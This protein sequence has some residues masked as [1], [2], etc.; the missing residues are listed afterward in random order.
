MKPR[1]YIDL[2]VKV[3]NDSGVHMSDQKLKTLEMKDLRTYGFIR[4]TGQLDSFLNDKNFMD[5]DYIRVKK[6][7]LENFKQP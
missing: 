3:M 6:Q 7:E 1:F 5:E 4:L 2:Y